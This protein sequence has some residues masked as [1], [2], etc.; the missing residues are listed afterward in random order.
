[1]KT[2]HLALVLLVGLLSFGFGADET[3]IKLNPTLVNGSFA[4]PLEQGWTTQADDIVG[5]HEFK[6][7]PENGLVVTKE[8]CGSATVVQDVSLKTTK[9]VFSAR[10][11]FAAQANK[12]DYYSSA[13]ILLGYLDKDENVL[14]ETRIV[15]IAGGLPWQG[16]GTLHLLRAPL[17]EWY[18]TKLNLADELR[19][20]LPGVDPAEVKRLRV[21]LEALCSGTSAC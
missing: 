6:A 5:S 12:P 15:A 9:V 4:K 7:T 11:R 14:G 8:M 3:D 17:G 13:S 2:G 19:E 16:S 1:M 18:D 10:T 20:N 21:S